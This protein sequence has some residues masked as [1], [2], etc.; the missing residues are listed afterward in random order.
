[1]HYANVSIAQIIATGNSIQE[2]VGGTHLASICAVFNVVSRARAAV[3][4]SN[5][6]A[7]RKAETEHTHCG[8]NSNRHSEKRDI[9]GQRQR[10][11]VPLAV[12][13]HHF[14]TE[15]MAQC[16]FVVAAVA[17]LILPVLLYL[18]VAAAVDL[19]LPH[20]VVALRRRRDDNGSPMDRR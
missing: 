1:M 15:L 5:A 13:W 14:Q 19:G 12:I 10:T 3:Y 9:V 8:Q 20:L 6:F 17:S 2:T 4:T 18:T 16:F 7:S 11:D